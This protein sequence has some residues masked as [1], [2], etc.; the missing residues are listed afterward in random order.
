M[1]GLMQLAYSNLACPGWNFEKTVEAVHTYGFDGLEIRLFDGEVVTP[2]ISAAARRRAEAAIRAAGV[3][4]AALDTSLQAAGPDAERFLAGVEVMAEI[5]EEWGAPLLRVFGGPLPQ[6][7]AA[8]SSELARVGDLLSRGAE[9]AGQYHVGIALETHDDFASAHTVGEVLHR[10]G[11]HVGAVY[12]AFHPHRVGE[13]PEEVLGQLGGYI[14]LVQ[15]KDA[16]RTGPEEWQLV[17]VGE[18]EVPVHELVQRLPAAGYDDW[19]SLEFE[20]KWHPEL[21][22]PEESLRPQ[23]ELLRHWLADSR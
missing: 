13:S 10:A 14:W 1:G 16:V 19:V 18:G 9:V 3:R 12:D 17:P 23:A 5:A 11:G 2:D 20:K 21:A 15:V 4:V 6:G 22:P 7:T 8:R